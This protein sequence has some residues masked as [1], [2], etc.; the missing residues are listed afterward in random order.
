[1]HLRPYRLPEHKRKFVQEELADKLRMG[2]IE[3]SHSAWCSPIVLMVKKFGS[4]GFCVH[5]RKVS[6]VCFDAYP[7]PRV[8][9]R[10]VRHWV[11]FTMLDLTKGYWLPTGYYLSVKRTSHLTDLTQKSPQDLFQWT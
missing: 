10:L 1:M 5:Y 4:I 11:F 9:P 6:K 2:V 3:D 8:A 7:I